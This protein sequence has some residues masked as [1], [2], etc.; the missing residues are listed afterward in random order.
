MNVMRN[1]MFSFLSFLILISS[2]TAQNPGVKGEKTYTGT[3][4]ESLTGGR[5]AYLFL[6]V[7]GEKIWIATMTDF[8][9]V[10]LDKGDK[11]E[12]VGGL[13]MK[14]FRSQTLDRTFE[15]IL[16]VTRIS[17]L[18]K[19]SIDVPSDD[20][21]SKKTENMVKAVPPR[22]NE[23]PKAENGMTIKEIISRRNE[24][25]GKEVILQAKVMKVSKNI[26]KKNWI[27]LQD[28]SGSPPND[29]IIFITDDI[30]RINEIMTIKGTVK[31]DVDL[32]G[33]YKYKVLLEKK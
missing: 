26:L 5:Y 27:T 28:G 1:V 23:I 25:K 32:G 9:N 22:E 17:V 24:L 14:D 11:V 16:F 10:S 6:E 4:I 13:P 18:T 2:A 3:V 29:K 31:T 15:S 21:H 12:Y 7:E 33:S 30:P 19:N 8:L 20:Y